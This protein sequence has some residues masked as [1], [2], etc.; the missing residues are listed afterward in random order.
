MNNFC[1]ASFFKNGSIYT[2]SSIHFDAKLWSV[3]HITSCNTSA[4]YLC[5]YMLPPRQSVKQLFR[6]ILPTGKITEKFAFV[7]GF[8]IKPKEN[9]F[10]YLCR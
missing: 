2:S 6:C 9:I 1:C 4:R 7:T 5:G 10:R 8:A 3:R